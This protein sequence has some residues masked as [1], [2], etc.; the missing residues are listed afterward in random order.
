MAAHL[1]LAL[2][3]GGILSCLVHLFGGLF[4]SADEWFFAGPIALMALIPVALRP[5]TPATTVAVWLLAT[6]FFGSYV[7]ED[8][9]YSGRTDL[10]EFFEWAML[11]VVLRYFHRRP[12][13]A[14]A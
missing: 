9:H 4:T 3:L 13:T 2:V 14:P 1:Q 8:L 12:M 6:A 11:G 7:D 5:R 10:L